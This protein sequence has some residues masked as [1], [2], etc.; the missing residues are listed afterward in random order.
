M[1][2]DLF[3]A[4]AS[5]QAYRRFAAQK[6]SRTALYLFFISLLFALAG[7]M[8]L[9]LRLGPIID[10]TFSWLEAQAPTLTFSAGKAA[11]ASAAPL[12]LAH[13]RVPEA[14]VMIDTG[15]AT[16]VTAL[17][18]REAKVIAY[19]TN[20]TLYLEERQG[21]LRSYDLSKAGEGKPLVID[22]KF[23]REAAGGLKIALVPISLVVLFSF[24]TAWIAMAGL[25]Y[26][27]LGLLLSS[28]AG[29]AL[30]FGALYQIAVHAQTAALLL[31]IA[32]AFLPFVVPLSGLLTI[33]VT[34]AYLWMG[35]RANAAASPEPRA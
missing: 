7:T 19:L 13:P 25:M 8:A 18:M 17:E 16:P 29:G 15:R 9:R 28:L 10:E 27:L 4:V 23:Y 24:C 3:G 12:R 35:V 20:D 5:T 11:S 33:A 34:T 1:L 30:A 2:E 26:A 31:R 22:A 6:A 32:M 21:E 14:A